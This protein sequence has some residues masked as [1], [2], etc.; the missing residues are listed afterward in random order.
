[1]TVVLSHFTGNT[2][3]SSG[4]AIFAEQ[5]SSLRLKLVSA[6]GNTAQYGAVIFLQGESAA[7]LSLVNLTQNT[8]TECGGSIA[9][10]S[11]SPI[12]IDNQV[13]ITENN[14]RNGGGICVL[15]R[16]EATQICDAHLG[17]Y[18]FLVHSLAGAALDISN[19]WADAGGGAFYAQCEWPGIATANLALTSQSDLQQGNLRLSGN[20]AG[21]G[22]VAAT[23]PV[24][25]TGGEEAAAQSYV[26]G[27]VLAATLRLSDC[28]GQ[29]VSRGAAAS[30]P[31][32]L[33]VLIPSPF[34]A[35]GVAE[36][37]VFCRRDGTCP[38]ADGRIPVLW[39]L[40]S[41]SSDRPLRRG[42][43]PRTFASFIRIVVDLR[44]ASGDVDAPLVAPLE[45]NL[46][47]LPCRAGTAYTPENWACIACR[48]S[49][50]V[51]DLD[52]VRIM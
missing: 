46:S 24:Q 26:P 37:S 33:I 6:S 25:I 16:N 27:D 3:L 18:P 12:S 10:N 35:G 38:L 23:Q 51:V 42:A 50:Y 4:A 11:T 9:I 1:V 14:A 28:F 2:A 34:A 52:Q 48:R 7:G 30:L 8:A 49:Q 39:P 40:V 36:E 45:F 32:E 13:R 20:T 21:Y 17:K 5:S 29:T 22:A 47:R 43:Q 15:L 41:S 44:Q 31:H 19:N